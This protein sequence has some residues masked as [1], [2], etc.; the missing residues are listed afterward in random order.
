MATSDV[1]D[2]AAS[3]ATRTASCGLRC[4]SLMTAI[5]LL[6]QC[7][8]SQSISYDSLFYGQEAMLMGGV[9]DVM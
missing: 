5:D 6:G 9:V 1:D 2:A 8:R 3:A 7:N 4:L